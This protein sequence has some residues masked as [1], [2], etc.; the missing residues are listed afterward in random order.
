AD[1]AH[2]DQA[3][4]EYQKAVAIQE[5]LTG[6]YPEVAAYQ[7][8]LA[9]TYAQSGLTHTKSGGWDRAT[10]RYRQALDLLDRLVGERPGVSDYAA[11]LAATRMRLGE[12]YNTSG[13]HKEAEEALKEAASAFERLLSDRSDT[14]PQDRATLA[15]CHAILGRVYRDTAQ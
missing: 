1:G 14:A 13:K 7:Y 10:A 9:K 3:Q 8:A 5:P 15:R 6:A 4:A 12:A 11:L 2:S